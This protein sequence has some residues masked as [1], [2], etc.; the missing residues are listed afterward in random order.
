MMQR[1][2][3]NRGYVKHGLLLF[4][5]FMSAQLVAS[6]DEALIEGKATYVTTPPVERSPDLLKKAWLDSHNNRRMEAG[7]TPLVWDDILAHDAHEWAQYLAK[8]NRFEH[9]VD[10][11]KNAQGENLWMGTRDRYHAEEMTGMWLDES[12][13]VKSGVF[14][15]ISHTGDW[16]D[17]AHYTQMMWPSTQR[18]G[19]A[20]ASNKEDDVL[21]CR[22]FPAGNRIGDRFDVKIGK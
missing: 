5:A 14:P 11:R 15:N 8:N 16:A 7:L 19:C 4:L 2:R 20:I 22:Y 9:F 12:S 17:V 18:L 21:V 3:Q 13:H 6:E 1:S 10:T